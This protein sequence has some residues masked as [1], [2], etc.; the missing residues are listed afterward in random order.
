[1]KKLV[2]LLI[3]I[4]LFLTFMPFKN[5]H[6]AVMEDY[7]AVPPYIIQNVAPNVM[8]VLDNSG[9]MFNFAYVDPG[10][11][12]LLDTSDD[13]MCT[14]PATP[15]T[16]FID[17]GIYPPSC[18]AY[19][20][21]P[22]AYFKYYGYFN[23]DYWYTYTSNR[24]VSA[25]PKTGSC[26]PGERAKAATEWDGNFL[27]WLTMRRVDV[28]RKVL[29]GGK[30]TGSGANTR[31]LGQIADYAGRG[32]Y[33]QILN[34]NDYTPY[35]ENKTFTFS[36]GGSGTSSFSV[37]GI[38][39]TFSVDVVVPPPV[40]GVLQ[41]VVGA[42]ARLGLSF[43][44]VNNPTPHGGFVQVNVGS[45]SLS[46]IVNQINN[47]P[48][49]LMG[50]TN[51]PLAETLWTVAGYFAQQ[52]TMEGGPGPMYKGGDYQINNDVDPLNYGTGGSPRWP[53][54]SKN[55]VLYI[56]DGEP[57]ADG[58][59]PAT[60]R[61]YASGKSGYNCSGTG[62]PAVG[63]FP[64]STFPSCTGGGESASCGG[65]VSGCYVAG[66]ED[67]ALYMNTT[68][69]R[70]AIPGKQKLVLYTVFAFGK[71]STLLRYAAINGGFEDL[72]GNNIPDLK[73]EWDKSG[74][75][76]PDN[77]FEATEGYR[78]EK[79]IEDAFS[80]ILSRASSG[81]AASVLASGEG[82]GANLVQAVFYPRR[83]FGDEIITWTGALQN[84]WYH[85]DPFFAK[86]SIR[87]ETVTDSLLNLT[88]DYIMQIY[89][90]TDTQTTKAK[91]WHDTDG[92]G[93]ADIVMPAV[94]FEDIS[95]LW[96]AGKLL[97]SRDLSA[98]PRTIY[99][100][101]DGSSLISFS[102]TNAG[103]LASYLQATDGTHASKIIGWVHGEDLIEDAD[104]DGVNDY[105][106]RTVTIGDETNVWK[107]GD[108]LSSTPRIAS[109]LQLNNYDT[110]YSDTT[111]KDFISSLTYKNRGMVFTGGNDGMLHAF[112]L[113]KLQLSGA[114]KDSVTKKAKLTNPDLST[115]IGHEA[116]AFIPRNALPYL[117]YI[118][119]PGYCHIYTVDLTP[120]LIDASI[121]GTP[122]DERTVSSWRTILIGGMRFGGACR[123]YN[124]SCT[125]CVKTP[126]DGVGFSSYFAFDVTDP[127]NPEL[128]WEFSHPRLGFTTTGP[129][130]VRIGDKAK[131]GNWFVVFGSGPTGPISTD[132]Q[133]MGRSDQNLRLFVLNLKTGNPERI[134]DSGI[135]FAFAGSMMNS[136]N[137]S[138][139]ISGGSGDYET[140]VLYI[141]YVKRAG[142]G[143]PANPYTWTNG[144]VGRLVTGE[145]PN[146]SDWKWSIV[147]D[148][149]GP[150]TSGVARIQNKKK[151]LLWLY[152]GTGR[153]YFVQE[154]GVDDHSSRR[155]IFGIKEPCFQTGDVPLKNECTAGSGIAV[156][157]ADLVDK[158][159]PTDALDCIN[160]PVPD[161]KDGWYIDLD[162]SETDF[163]AERVITDPE[164][165]T[166]GVV[167]FTTIRPYTDVCAIGGRSTM[168]AVKYDTGGSPGSTLKGIAILQV[169][170]AAIEQI[171]LSKAFTKRG[172][173]KPPMDMEIEGI[174]GGTPATLLP[175]P[176]VKRTIH[177]RER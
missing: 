174:T 111:Y 169:S 53:W 98:D 28:I 9:S 80:S 117:K 37:S 73:A 157:L 146:P 168:W 60:L 56:T 102:I 13:H 139:L 47:D 141:P 96:E 55:F 25:G 69:L 44:R 89:F 36:T 113:G 84:L 128:L 121:E 106:L 76:E 115:P 24:F 152:F 19:Q 124:A 66:I 63:P 30:T 87:E 65:I 16:G 29:A 114:W 166:M 154:S 103:T 85:V 123:N 144:G 161:N 135:Q 172:G 50:K 170:T 131:N 97:W 83:R 133:F 171:D 41:R 43:Y 34:A 59:L 107:L 176:P 127:N 150:V 137:D 130:I 112:K 18:A 134:I 64:A 58:Y 136:Q 22:S 35:S 122:D 163:G 177:M 91:R 52:A 6:S 109:W 90:D 1:M 26:I 20:A 71:G 14:D 145:D 8:I 92:D 49:S 119:D 54:C 32:I 38:G 138:D 165:T 108:I 101:V 88:N 46:S 62:C 164:A 116:W 143:T 153:Y 7:C 158:T 77:F 120:Y 61:D 51:T 175:P 72:N 95:N 94:Q 2:F 5:S 68:D 39:G 42:R 70:P 167:F 48:S 151:G 21:N 15:C 105:R 11:D 159:C 147:I 40:E 10:A 33:K 75:G 110:R 160:A 86:S 27:N 99:T 162:P 3:A 93:D 148:N 12:G 74:N 126:V 100:T 156:A 78:L 81:T 17:R 173:R 129:A 140:D 79:A 67:V 104:G 132:W 31:L 45:L 23:P 82:Q 155:R 4:S 149:I 57:C 118:A 142:A 125:D